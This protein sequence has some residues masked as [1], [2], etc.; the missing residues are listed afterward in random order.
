MSQGR[1]TVH[2]EDVAGVHD[3]THGRRR[4]PREGA[5]HCFR[6]VRESARTQRAGIGEI[7]VRDS[8]GD[9][10]CRAEHRPRRE[11]RH[12]R[13]VGSDGVRTA[14]GITQVR[15]SRVRVDHSLGG[16]GRARREG[17]QCIRVSRRHGR[18]LG[19]SEGSAAATSHLR[20]RGIGTEDTRRRTGAA[21]QDAHAREVER[22]CQAQPRG[23]AN[24]MGR[25]GRAQ[26]T[27]HAAHAQSGVSDDDDRPNAPGR[28]DAGDEIG[29]RGDEKRDALPRS[30]AHVEQARGDLPR[31]RGEH[32]P[33]HAA[34]GAQVGQGHAGVAGAILERL[35]HRDHGGRVRCLRRRTAI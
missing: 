26:R 35:T 30:H 27:T 28:V 34:V 5:S 14:Q 13:V 10:Q 16:A 15:E 24:D 11:G 33:A 29:A 17:H 32:R 6:G 7:H 4:C 21:H 20:Q 3:G 31:P 25:L 19:G 8:G 18:Q 1:T 9:T 22:A 12:Q 23:D 2:V